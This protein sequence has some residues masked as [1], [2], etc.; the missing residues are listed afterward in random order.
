VTPFES[1]V[2]GHLLGDYVFQNT[3]MAENKKSRWLPCLVH[4]LIYTFFVALATNFSPLWVCAIFLTHF[5]ID[6]WGWVDKWMVMWGSRSPSKFL[7]LQSTIG[8]DLNKH[9]LVGGFTAFVYIVV[10][11]TIHLVLML[12][13]Y[14]TFRNFGL[15]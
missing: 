2:V 12:A 10:D 9:I 13:A 5:P 4:C 6:K 7:G 8:G 14:F 1:I 11:N 15:M 3:W